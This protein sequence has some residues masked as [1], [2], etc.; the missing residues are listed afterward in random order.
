M[1]KKKMKRSE[2]TFFFNFT[3][4][5]DEPTTLLFTVKKNHILNDVD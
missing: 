2:K 3:I 1:N 4:R 5:F